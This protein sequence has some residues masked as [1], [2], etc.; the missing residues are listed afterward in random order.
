MTLVRSKYFMLKANFPKQAILIDQEPILDNHAAP[1][2]GF[3]AD[4]AEAQSE[5]AKGEEA[6]QIRTSSMMDDAKHT[7]QAVAD[8]HENTEEERLA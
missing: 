6:Q 3:S 2:V 5:P 1:R 8:S 7:L 4:T